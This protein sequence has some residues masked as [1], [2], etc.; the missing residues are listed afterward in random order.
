MKLKSKKVAILVDDLYQVVEFWYPYYRL[1]EEGAEIKVISRAETHLTIH[2]YPS[3]K[4]DIVPADARAAD[5]DAVV[6]PGGIAPDRMRVEK[7]ILRFVR[8]MDSAGKLVAAICHAAWVPISAG[9]VRGRTMTCLRSVRDDVINA[10]AEYVDRDVVRDRNLITSRTP[11]DLPAFCRE[12]IAALQSA[13][14]IAAASRNDERTW[15][16]KDNENVR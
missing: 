9:F 4:R 5:F 2:G 16:G 7:D 3:A 6:I 13:K 15:P 10:G 8:E 1:L 12:I 11:D 14:E